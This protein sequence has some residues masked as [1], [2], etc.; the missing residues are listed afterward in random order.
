MAVRS[1]RFAGLSSTTRMFAEWR[2]VG[3]FIR[4]LP[5][6]TQCGSRVEYHPTTTA[7]PHEFLYKM[8]KPEKLVP[9]GVPLFVG[10][11]EP[12]ATKFVQRVLLLNDTPPVV[13]F[14]REQ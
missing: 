10:N 3:V 14:V 9:L 13:G 8:R 5:Y 4:S 1:C 12:A 11:V 6:R 2:A 7:T